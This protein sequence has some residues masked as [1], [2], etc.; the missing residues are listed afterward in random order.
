[1]E[2]TVLGCGTNIP[3]LK[4]AGPSFYVKDGKNAV[5]LDMGPG[6][7]RNMLKSGIDRF[8]ITDIIF[9]H[10]HLDHFADL[11]AFL[12]NA[13]YNSVLVK[14]RKEILNIYGPKGFSSFIKPIFKYPLLRRINFPIKLKDLWKSPVKIKNFKIKTLPVFHTDINAM[15]VRIEIGKKSLVYSGDTGMCENI[16]KI[17]KDTDL[18]IY[19]CAFPKKIK[20]PMHLNSKEIGEIAQKANVKQVVLTHLYPVAEKGNVKKEVAEIYKGKIIVAKDL[21]KIKI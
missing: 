4:K 5:L 7:L 14:P 6:S 2:L 16:V 9:T 11:F 20:N 15:A 21:L 8:K 13:G 19:E 10:N 17:S 1:M 3:N 12:F 18:G